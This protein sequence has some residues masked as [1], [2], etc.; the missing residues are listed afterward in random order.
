MIAGTASKSQVQQ[1]LYAFDPERGCNRWF[2]FETLAD[3]LAEIN[4]EGSVLG[5]SISG[6]SVPARAVVFLDEE[7]DAYWYQFD[8]R[9]SVVNAAGRHDLNVVI[10]E[11]LHFSTFAGP[12]PS[13]KAVTTIPW[14]ARSI[15][16]SRCSPQS[17]LLFGGSMQWRHLRRR[18]NTYRI[19]DG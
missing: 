10:T 9:R 14:L 18:R 4:R 3:F 6:T 5:R 17:L 15:R 12:L 11:F 13:R 8:S 7:E 1:Q 16:I 2:K 19:N